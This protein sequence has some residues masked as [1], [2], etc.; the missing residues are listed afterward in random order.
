MSNDLTTEPAVG[1][2]AL[3]TFVD[4]T[5]RPPIGRADQASPFVPHKHAVRG[6]V[7][8]VAM[9]ALR[10]VMY[11]KAGPSGSDRLQSTERLGRPTGTWR[12]SARRRP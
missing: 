2:D 11:A 7:C 6:V 12:S 1:V 9:S 3:E 8:E 10:E 5:G 4:L